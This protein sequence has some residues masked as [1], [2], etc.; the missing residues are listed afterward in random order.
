MEKLREIHYS[1]NGYWHGQKA[2]DILCKKTGL[3]I[4]EV[5]HWIKRQ[6]IWQIYLPRPKYIPRPKI[7]E[8][9]PNGF[10]QTDILY[11][12]HD[13]VG[14]KTY[15]YCLC[16]IDVAS[17][18]KDAEPLLDKTA[19]Q[20]TAAIEKI[21]KRGP[22]KFPNLIQVDAGREFLGTFTKLMAK[23]KV[24]VRVATPGNHRQQGIVERF[25]RTLSERLF[26]AQYHEE[27]NPSQRSTKWVKDLPAVIDELNSHATRLTGHIPHEA[28]QSPTVSNSSLPAGPA[29]RDEKIISSTAI[30]RYLF[31]PIFRLSMDPLN[32]LPFI[33]QL[34]NQYSPEDTFP[35]VTITIN[36]TSLS[37]SSQTL[38]K[39]LLQKHL[40]WVS[41]CTFRH[42]TIHV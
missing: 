5:T 12:P 42:S 35:I 19:A 36:C 26:K 1:K 6:P 38:I 13:T 3:S 10:H 9:I 39:D 40:Q 28:I 30:I 20:T 37:L 11:L 14:R 2:I 4:K 31:P 41:T 25:N 7:E 29:S 17:R 34:F 18:Y 24:K 22:L 8:V 23:K 27:I 32:A 16:I 33:D 15:K 21:Y